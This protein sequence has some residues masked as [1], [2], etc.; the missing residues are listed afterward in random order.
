MLKK[1]SIFTGFIVA[2]FSVCFFSRIGSLY[3]KPLMTPQ[4]FLSNMPYI[5]LSILN[6]DFILIQPSSTF[7]VYLLGIVM[8][9]VGFYFIKNQKDQRSRYY[10]GLGLILWGLSALVAGTSYQAFGYEL[11]CRGQEYC[12]YTSNFELVYMLLTAF[13]VNFL[14][15]ATGYTSLGVHDRKKLIYF[16]VA[17]NILYTIYLMIGAVVPI[18]FIISYEGFIAFIGINFI[19]MF[20]CNVRQ[21]FKN[22]DIVS[23]NSIIIWISFLVVN[24]LYF[25]SLFSGFPDILYYKY[26]IWF[27]ENDVLHVLLILWVLLVFL[28]FKTELVDRDNWK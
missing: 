20:I 8:V 3:L 6:S 14:I 15:I 24:I 22:K 16:A 27:N 28:L 13:C 25:I 18:Q 21:Y 17:D 23:R 10:W 5:N 26:N 2:I 9:A 12:L 7:F 19:I 11:K 4:I 1:I